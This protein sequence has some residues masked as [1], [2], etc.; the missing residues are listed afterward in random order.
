VSHAHILVV[1]DERGIL[2]Q[3][4][5][6]LRDEGFAVTAVE[7][8]E[9]AVAATARELYDLVLLDVALPGMDGLEALRR[10]RAAG[11]T[12]PVVMISGHASA[13]QVVSAL[14]EGAIDF[15]DKPLALERVLVTVN[16]ALA[17][18]RLAE[19]LAAEREGE[20][21]VLTGV[22]PAVAELR[23]Q[24][25]LA[26]P[27]DSRVLISG[28]NGAGKEVVARLLHRISRRAG[29]PFVAVNCAAIPAELIE[30]ELFGHLK[31]AFTGA[32]ENKRGKFELADGGTLFLDEVADMSLLTQAKVLRVLQESS[33]TRLGGAQEVRVDVRVIAATNKNLED[34]IA[35]GRF[36]QDLLFR[37]NVIP[38]R[39][40]PLGERREDVPL[41]VE[42]FMREFSRR[43]GVRPKRIGPQAMAALQAY[44]WPGNVREVRNVVERLMIMVAGDE[45][46]TASLNLPSGGAPAEPDLGFT[47]LREARERFERRY[48]ERVVAACGGNM[49]QAARLLGLERSHLY[50]KRRALGLRA[51]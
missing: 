36:R 37:L 13:E 19:R 2:E 12:V 15:M 50:R 20:E 51:R 32:V 5:G 47:T 18:A 22:S 1:D 34:E 6:I 35:A 48:V 8:G 23:R 7:S 49:S 42:E 40:P 33:F 11:H 10:I 24:I 25:A 16:N 27:T 41:L 45:I 43:T 4:G 29:N 31:G 44:P 14:R 38:V 39:V 28:P 30:S 9:A 17:R 3:L 26:A 46:D 21:P